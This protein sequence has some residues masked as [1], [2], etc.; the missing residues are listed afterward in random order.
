MKV[1]FLFVWHSMSVSFMYLSIRLSQ[2]GK[3]HLQQISTRSFGKLPLYVCINILFKRNGLFKIGV[4]RSRTYSL[5]SL[6][7]GLEHHR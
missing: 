3:H 6:D 7:V 4:N 2:V 1:N 5:Y